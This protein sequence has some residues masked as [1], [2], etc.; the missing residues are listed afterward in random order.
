MWNRTP[1]G[2]SPTL[3]RDCPASCSSSASASPVS[4]STYSAA[5]SVKPP[6][7]T[8]R[9]RRAARPSG[10]RRFQ[11]QS[12]TARRVRCRS[13]ASRLPPRSSEN[14][15]RSLR[16]MSATEST[17]TRAAASSTAS[18]SPSRCRQ[19]SPT[20]AAGSSTPGRAA[21]ARCT[22]SSTEVAWESSGRAY[23]DSDVSPSGAR[24]VA[25]TRSSLDR[26]TSAWTRAAAPATTCSQLSSTSSA[27][28]AP[29]APTMPLS[30]SP[31]LA[32]GRPSPAPTAEATS[33]ATSSSAVTP[34]S[35]TK[36]T[37]GC[38]AARLTAWERRVL[39]SPP[40]PTTVTTRASRSSPVTAARSA[41]R[42]SSGFGSCGTP[43][44]TGGASA[45]SNSW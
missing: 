34:A 31:P 28:P 4:P 15:S 33:P 22:K 16:E 17:R 3:I 24:L 13:G 21:R 5:S 10:S 44:R 37:T 8:D 18:G 2:L 40:G 19:I 35:G 20:S 45:L 32:Y 1:E 39:P 42:P 30:T 38:S 43:C 25:R 27:G 23:T 11:L 9:A 26:D 41:S 6:G 36:C 7:N 12:T 29:S 14:R